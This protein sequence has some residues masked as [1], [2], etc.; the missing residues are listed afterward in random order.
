[1][2]IELVCERDDLVGQ[3][4]CPHTPVV[5]FGERNGARLEVEL[6]GAG[7]HLMDQT[8]IVESSH[9]GFLLFLVAAE[10]IRLFG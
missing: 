7:R 8:T 1:M 9:A 6:P 4:G 3:L 10:S 5:F 2:R